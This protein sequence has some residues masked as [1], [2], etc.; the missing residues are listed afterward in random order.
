MTRVRQPSLLVVHPV[1]SHQAA[2]L[3]RFAPESQ[4]REAPARDV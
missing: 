1:N 2:E 4:T 3:I